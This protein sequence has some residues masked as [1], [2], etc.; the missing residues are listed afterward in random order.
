MRSDFDAA[1]TATAWTS[2]ARK[3]LPEA[4]P[5]RYGTYEPMTQKLD[6]DGEQAFI[7]FVRDADGTVYFNG[8]Q[9]VQGGHMD[10]G[11]Q[12]GNASAHG[13]TL[14]APALG[15]P[16]WRAALRGL[17]IDF[18]LAVDAIV[19]TAEVVRGVHWSGR[20]L[21]YSGDT[22]RTAHL[23][24]KNFWQGLPPYPVWW[25]WFGPDYVNVVIE[26]LP[27][28]QVESFGS[29]L[30][31][32]HSDVPADR[33]ALTDLNAER[34]RS[35]PVPALGNAGTQSSPWLPHDFLLTQQHEAIMA[36]GVPQ[37]A[38]WVPPSLA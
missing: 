19:A 11:P 30:F 32:C 34:S 13:L 38:R 1:E 4:L 3:R 35:R 5:R 33:N 17:F 37:R 36:Y 24:W 7:D 6:I 8:R 25:T 15:N 9:P 21:G 28:D 23:A 2:L 14:L 10:A 20:S 29:G 22:E 27:R 12:R 31:H 16:R 18:A 26:H